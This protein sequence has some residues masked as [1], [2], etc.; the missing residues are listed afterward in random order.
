[1]SDLV[2]D[3][4]GRVTDRT[5]EVGEAQ[6][7]TSIIVAAELHYGALWRRKDAE[8]LIRARLERSGRPIGGNDL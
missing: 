4:K 1:M 5:R 8:E 2:R 6:V 7:C 3:P